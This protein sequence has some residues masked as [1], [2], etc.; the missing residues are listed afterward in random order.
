MT[1]QV[2]LSR[3]WEDGKT[4]NYGLPSKKMKDFSLLRIKDLGIY[5]HIRLENIL[6]FCCYV[7]MKMGF[8]L[9]WNYYN[10]L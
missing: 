5:A 3:E 1:R 10:K 6:V 8:V 7:L 4:L 2:L 9:C